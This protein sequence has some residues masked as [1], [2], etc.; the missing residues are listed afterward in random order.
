M[1]PISSTRM[2]LLARKVQ[3]RLAKQGHDLLEQKRSALIEELK[4]T[5]EALFQ[6]ATSVQEMAATARRVLARAHAIAGT[7]AVESAALAARAELNLEIR[8]T[9]V[10]G[11]LIPVIEQKPVMRSMLDRGY[12]IVGTS[13]TIDETAG[14]FEAEVDAILHLAG[15][16]LRL[17]RLLA[18]IQRTSRR[19]NALEHI[20]IPRLESELHYIEM[21]LDERERSDHYRLKLAKQALERRS[22]PQPEPASA[23][24]AL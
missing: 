4:R 22:Q 8:S 14:A 18:E 21:T 2:E 10:M 16:E 11:V 17:K 19:L 1:K 15:A 3:I 9:N 23:D 20:L 24:R 5:T 7:E 13:L 6:E 12:S